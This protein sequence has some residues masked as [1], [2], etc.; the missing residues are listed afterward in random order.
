MIKLR[1]LICLF[2]FVICMDVKAVDT[3]STD[4]LARLK[5]LANNV[6]I[7]Y[8]YELVKYDVEDY[9]IEEYG[10]NYNFEPVFKLKVLNLSDNLKIYFNEDGSDYNKIESQD[11]ETIN[12]FE[13]NV[14]KFNI[15]SYTDTDCTYRNLRNITIKLPFYNKYYYVNKDKCSQYPNFKYC[16]E[17]KYLFHMGV[18]R[19]HLNKLPN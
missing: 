16:I 18:I 19:K 15:Y 3:C 6:E 2:L 13:G 4:E 12:F 14:L 7:K 11:L 1:Y 5:E 17:C 10:E 9:Y 8:E